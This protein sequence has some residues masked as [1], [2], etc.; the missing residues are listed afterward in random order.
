[1]PGG[2]ERARNIASKCDLVF[3]SNYEHGLKLFGDISSYLMPITYREDYFTKKEKDI[4]VVMI[5]NPNS[6]ERVELW[7][8]LGKYN[9]FAGSTDSLE[10]Y[11]DVMSRARIVINQPT[12]P[13]DII[14]NNRFF[15]GIGCGALLLQKRL[16]TSLI[17]EM[18]FRNGTDFIYWDS[19]VYLPTQ[20]D[21]IL[22]NFDSYKGIVESGHQKVKAYEMKIQMRKIEGL[23]LHKFYGRL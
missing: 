17:E 6:R 9:S 3:S 20:I 1:M 15:E 23:I 13:W 7:N 8:M 14:L 5:G 19:L 4:D 2:L 18:G 10:K 21:T 16:K 12:E 11:S 22:T